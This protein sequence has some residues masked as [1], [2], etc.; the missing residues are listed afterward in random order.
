MS[1]AEAYTL[2]KPLDC[3]AFLVRPSTKS[4]GSFVVSFKSR[5]GKIVHALV[6]R[7]KE[8]GEWETTGVSRT[9]AS[10]EEMIRKYVS[11]GIYTFPAVVKR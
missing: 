5:D 9:F 4:E 1:S 7:K 8:T 11:A 3:G 6:S 10:I 2:L